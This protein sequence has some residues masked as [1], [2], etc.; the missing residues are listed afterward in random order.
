MIIYFL[1]IGIYIYYFSSHPHP[2]I[3][4]SALS[5]L[6]MLPI[7]FFWLCFFH[8]QPFCPFSSQVSLLKFSLILLNSIISLVAFFFCIDDFLCR[9]C[10]GLI[11]PLSIHFQAIDQFF[12]QE[13]F[14][15][16]YSS[17]ILPISECC[18][19]F[20]TFLV[21]SVVV[22]MSLGLYVFS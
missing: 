15:M 21:F 8:L 20:L 5:P 3:L 13:K 14:E 22:H 19:S 18:L 17:D 10:I 16:K 7:C 11:F 4:S 6:P 2:D 1:L 12:L 9:S